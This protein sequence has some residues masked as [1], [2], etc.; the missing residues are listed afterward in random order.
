MM[1]KQMTKKLRRDEEESETGRIRFRRV[2]FQT[3]SSVSFF[4]LT[5]IRGES[6]LTAF[7]AELTELATELSAFSLPKQCSRNSVPPI[8]QRE[9]KHKTQNLKL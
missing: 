7:F 2:Q 9:K 6:E 4:A 8:S 3:P 5:E 1:P